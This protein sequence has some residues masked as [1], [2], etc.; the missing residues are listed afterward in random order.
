MPP[1]GRRLRHVVRKLLASAD[2]SA[3]RTALSGWTRQDVDDLARLAMF[4]DNLRELG[5]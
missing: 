4:F 2:A 1:I 3:P 5:S